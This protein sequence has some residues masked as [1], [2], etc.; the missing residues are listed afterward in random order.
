MRVAPQARHRPNEGA[1]AQDPQRA[2]CLRHPVQRPHAHRRVGQVRHTL[3]PGRDSCHTSA[4]AVLIILLFLQHRLPQGEGV[5]QAPH[6][7]LPEPVA[8]PGLLRLPLRARGSCLAR[9]LCVVGADRVCNDY[10]INS[11]SMH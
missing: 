11:C 4:G 7:A 8:R 3:P 2:A 9:E 1:Q 5:G 6:Q 10:T